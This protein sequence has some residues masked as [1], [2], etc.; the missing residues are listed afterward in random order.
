M[1]CILSLLF[2][3]YCSLLLLLLLLLSPCPSPSLSSLFSCSFFLSSSFQRQSTRTEGAPAQINVSTSIHVASTTEKSFTVYMIDLIDANGS[4]S[5]ILKRYRQF[6]TLHKHVSP[7]LPLPLPLLLAS[8]SLFFSLILFL[9]LL[10]FLFFFFLLLSS[11][12]SSV[13]VAKRYP[14]H[15]LPGLPKKHLIGNM[16]SDLVQRRCQ[17]LQNYLRQL[18]L[19]PNIFSTEEMQEFITNSTVIQQTPF[20]SG[21]T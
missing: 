5:T 19:L 7:S 20:F 14:K 17:K 12:S 16:E 13:Q 3:S 9:L 4:K 10:H 1:T 21:Q 11:S 15:T 6:T 8:T 18:A 2:S